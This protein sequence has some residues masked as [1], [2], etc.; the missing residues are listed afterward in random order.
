MPVRLFFSGS[1]PGT[2]SGPPLRF[3]GQG[4]PL[5]KSER[6]WQRK[7]NTN[8][9]TLPWHGTTGVAL[10]REEEAD[11]RHTQVGKRRYSVPFY[12]KSYI[13]A[14]GCSMVRLTGRTGGA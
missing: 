3:Y 14:S 12:T 1:Y 9:T 6:K 2:Q 10:H 4:V 13:G 7:K 5:R 11:L 8:T